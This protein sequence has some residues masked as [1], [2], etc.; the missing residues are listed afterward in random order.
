MN[1]DMG[2]NS[3]A[4]LVQSVPPVAASQ[5]AFSFPKKTF[6]RNVSDQGR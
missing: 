4:A 3:I 5:H 1:S 6:K 2:R